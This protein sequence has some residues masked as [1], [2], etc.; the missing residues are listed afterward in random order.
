M[1]GWSYTQNNCLIGNTDHHNVIALRHKFKIYIVLNSNNDS[2]LMRAF[3]YTVNSTVTATLN[4]VQMKY[5]PA[6]SNFVEIIII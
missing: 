3:K 2:H 4:A 6:I 1:T 5:K